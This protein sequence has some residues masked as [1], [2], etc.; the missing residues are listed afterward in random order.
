VFVVGGDDVAGWTLVGHDEL[1]VLALGHADVGGVLPDH[2]GEVPDAFCEAGL[3]EVLPGFVQLA[4][5]GFGS[6]VLVVLY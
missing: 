3:L 5:P 4:V 2:A 1:A 6:R